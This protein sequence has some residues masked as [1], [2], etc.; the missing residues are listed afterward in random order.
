MATCCFSASTSSRRGAA[1]PA[2]PRVVEAVAAAE[3]VDD[4]Q[5]RYGRQEL[6][7]AGDVSSRYKKKRRLKARTVGVGSDAHYLL[8]FCGMEL[9]GLRGLTEPGSWCDRISFD[10]GEPAP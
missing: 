6:H 10:E 2:R 8:T 7:V 4:K 9:G 1:E 5:T 3:E